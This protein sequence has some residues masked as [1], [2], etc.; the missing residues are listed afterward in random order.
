MHKFDD[1]T[2]ASYLLIRNSSGSSMEAFTRQ[3]SSTSLNAYIVSITLFLCESNNVEALSVV[4]VFTEEIQ[5]D[6]NIY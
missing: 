1:Q 2:K 4:E 3:G 5:I 6:I